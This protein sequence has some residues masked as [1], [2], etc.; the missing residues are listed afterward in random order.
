[1]VVRGASSWV[2]AV[3][4]LAVMAIACGSTNGD[5][6]GNSGALAD[7]ECTPWSAGEA[8]AAALEGGASEVFVDC[9]KHLRYTRTLEADGAL[10]NETIVDVGTG[11]KNVW[12][13][14]PT[15]MTYR[16]FPAEGAQSDH[17]FEVEASRDS[18]GPTTFRATDDTDGNGVVDQRFSGTITPG[19]SGIAVTLET[20]YD[21]TGAWSAEFSGTQSM[22]QK[23]VFINTDKNDPGYC[24]PEDAKKLRELL[25]KAVNQGTKCLSDV[26]DKDLAVRLR[27]LIVSGQKSLTI[28][29]RPTQTEDESHPA[30]PSKDACL[31]TEMNGFQATFTSMSNTW[32]IWAYPH[33]FDNANGNCAVPESHVFHELLHTL[34]GTHKI[35]DGA[36]DPN[37]RF[38]GC[39]IMCFA[40][41]EKRTTQHCAACLMTKNE[42]ARCKKF[43]KVACAPQP[44]Y[45]DCGGTPWPG[46]NQWYPD[47]LTCV[48]ECPTNNMAC[49]TARCVDTGG[50]C[51]AM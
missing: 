28:S 43:K 5:V 41:E 47:P 34:L 36:D 1:M 45:C 16:A 25:I 11:S 24:K 6:G 40:P 23:S 44:M 17:V 8:A 10:S 35:G 39:Q 14:T 19:A 18:K 20:D 48:N 38:Y 22:F 4:A 21:E 13:Y 49:F 46:A 12:D 30:P 33:L 26:G 31:F 2:G 29:C 42:D 7:G 3:G 32:K 27:K 9:E 50:P 15:K 37:D 51:R